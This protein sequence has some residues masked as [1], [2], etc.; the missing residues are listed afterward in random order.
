[1]NNL[2]GR[3]PTLVGNLCDALVGNLDEG[4]HVQVRELLLQI[5]DKFGRVGNRG[6]VR[7]GIVLGVL[8]GGVDVRIRSR[9]RLC[10]HVTLALLEHRSGRGLVLAILG[11]NLL[12]F[13]V[14]VVYVLNLIAIRRNQQPLVHIDHINVYE[15]I[16]LLKTLRVRLRL[17]ARS[18][19]PANLH[20][21]LLIL[22][23]KV[24]TDER[25]A[26]KKLS[27]NRQVILLE[28]S[29]LKEKGVSFLSRM[30]TCEEIRKL[31]NLCKRELISEW[32]APNSN[33][34]DCGCGRG[35]DWWKWKAVRARVWAID[36]DSESL[37]EA[38]MRANEM[39]MNVRFLGVGTIVQGAF[40]GPFDVVCYNFALH[41]IFETPEIYDVSLR[42]LKSAVRKNGLL[43]G[44]VPDKARAEM[45]VDSYGYFTDPVGNEIALLHGGRTLMV[46]LVDGPF[47]AEGGREEPTLDPSVFIPDMQNYGFELVTWEPMLRQPNGY[48][49]DLYSKFVF[50]KMSDD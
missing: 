43:I 37:R 41:Y 47:Y 38:E 50:K 10:G 39:N 28:R 24:R 34:L 23:W 26:R 4:R 3:L 17:G 33:V 18:E 9:K 21:E 35:G 31:H 13:L 42:A 29:H 19:T 1:M 12:E 7:F 45:M 48:I 14:L 27:W 2:Y 6:N 44:I 20:T 11:H 22:L 25:N 40:A 36:P 30:T 16:L 15:S 8:I 46:R 32:V 5:I 49:S